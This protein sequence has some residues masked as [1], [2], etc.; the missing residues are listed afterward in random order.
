VHAFGKGARAIA[1]YREF[2]AAGRE[3]GYDPWTMVKGQ[4]YL[5]GE[6]FHRRVESKLRHM[7]VSDQVPSIQRKPSL[8]TPE[9]IGIIRKVLGV[10]IEEMRARPRNLIAERR[11]TADF[12]RQECLMPMKGIG[13]SLGVKPW[14]A[15]ALARAGEESDDQRRVRLRSTRV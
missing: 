6:E 9:A 1:K 12:L 14:Q 15:S 8:P 3:S 10:T 7:T 2:V 13:E 11:L 5:G 4:I